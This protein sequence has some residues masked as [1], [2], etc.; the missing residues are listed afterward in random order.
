MRVDGDYLGDEGSLS[1]AMAMWPR[2]IERFKRKYDNT[3]VGN[4][5]RVE[6]IGR[7]LKRMHILL[8]L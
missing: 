5:F 6:I 2:H 1:R 4:F 7:I 3:F 8:N